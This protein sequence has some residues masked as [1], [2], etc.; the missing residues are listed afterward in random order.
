MTGKSKPD[1]MTLTAE[2]VGGASFELTS[3]Q[4][5]ADDLTKLEWQHASVTIE[6]AT[7]DTR[8]ILRP[9][10]VDPYVSNAARGQN[11]WYL[12]NIKIVTR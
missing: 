2:V 12:D 9:T 7:A 8:I 11:R 10:N 4:P 3:A 6:G 5:T 1:I